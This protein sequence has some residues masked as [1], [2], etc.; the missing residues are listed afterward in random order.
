[1]ERE[2]AIQ[3]IKKCLALSK[4]PNPHEAA[5]ALRQA[6]K[7]MAAHQV[8]DVDIDLS[9]VSEHDTPLAVGAKSAW[10]SLL[11]GTC[12]EAFGCQFIFKLGGG[13]NRATFIGLHGAAQVASYA[14]DVLLRQVQRDRAH[15]ITAQPKSCKRVTKIARG[16]AFALGWVRA[17]AAL[18]ERMA[19]SDAEQAARAALIA[20][21]KQR[22]FKG[23]ESFRPERRDLKGRVTPNSYLLGD[24]AGRAAELHNAVGAK[25]QELLA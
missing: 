20:Q 21:Y 3:K 14:F 13:D 9:C 6:Q 22:Q 7:L 4:S 5:A 18:V 12:A 8:D 17:A 25:R 10:L 15:H 11:A 24:A 19:G 23:L 1:M 2:T 16:D